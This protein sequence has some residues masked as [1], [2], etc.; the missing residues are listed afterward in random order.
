M[1]SNKKP[2]DPYLISPDQ[3]LLRNLVGAETFE[4]L[5]TAES[6]LFHVRVLQL[7]D[8][9]TVPPTRDADEIK[10][11]HR[12]LFQDVY[13][14]AGEYRTI[15]MRRGNGE[16]FAPWSHILYLVDNL[17]LKLEEDRF[18]AGLSRADFVRKLTEYYDELNYIHP[19]R[20]GNGRLQRTFW[21]R[22]AFYAGWVLDWRPIQGEELNETSRIA[23]E[24]GELEPLHEAL[25]KCV[26]PLSES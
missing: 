26:A 12:H 22:V 17:A 16:H 10:G 8:H 9:D 11:L 23:R 2:H 24:L 3:N 15:D 20:E 21:S 1:V 13:D 19:F 6:D 4:Q 14:W 25:N 7:Q 18:L 5:A